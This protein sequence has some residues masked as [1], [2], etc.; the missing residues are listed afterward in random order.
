MNFLIKALRSLAAGVCLSLLILGFPANAG[1]QSQATTGE[2][3]GRVV[4]AQGAAMPGVSVTAK[5]PQTGYVR[6]VVTDGEGL[7]ALPLMPPD[8]YDV[9]YELAG[10]GTV[11]RPIILTVGSTLTANQTLQ[12]SSVAETLTVTASSPLIESSATIRTTTV[13]AQAIRNLPINGRRFQDFATLT[14]TIQVDTQRGQLSFA[15]QRGINA[16]VSIDGADYNQ[17][18]FGGIRGGERS[19]NAFTVP[20]ESIQEFQVIAAG[21]SAEFGRSTGGLMNAITKS[22]TNSVRGTAFYVNRNRDWAEKNAFDQNAAPTQQQFGGS[23]GGPLTKDRLFYFG[24]LEVQKF[25]NTRSVLFN[26]TGISRNS[27]NGEAFDY[28]KS[29]ETP[30]DTTNDAVGLLGRMDYQF[31]GGKRFNIRYSFSDNNAK[32]ANATGNALADTTTSALSNNGTEKDQT[33]TVVGQYTAALKSNLLFEARGQFSREERPRDANE[34]TPLVTTAVGN[35]GTVSF[36]GENI[37]RDWRAQATANVTGVLGRHTVKTGVEYNHVDAFQKFGFNQFGTWNISGTSAVA[38]EILSLGGPNAN[39]FD[40]VSPTATYQKQLGN[41]ELALAT[42]E[43][44]LFAQDTWKVKPGLTLNYGLRWEGAFNPTPQAN[45]DFML[46]ALRGFNFPLGRSV[47]PTQIPDQ[48]SQLGPRVGFA[49][50]PQNNGRTVVRG[51]TGIYYARTPML[52]Y[53]A[54]M[55]NFRIPPGDLSVSLPFTPPAGNTNNTLYKQMALIGIDLNKFPLNGLPVLTTDQI[56]QIASALGLTVNPYLNAAPLVVDRDYKNPRAVQAGVG[57]ERELWPGVT[58]SADMTYVKT[59]NLER[60]RELNLGVPE[61]RPTDPAQRPI[62]ATA[63][64]QPLLGSVQVREPTA[65]SEYTALTLSNRVRK[66]W[67]EVSVNYVLSKS[68][69][70]DDNERDSGGPQYENTYDLSPE[71][72]PARLD[73]R[74]QFNGYVYFFLPYNLDVSTGFKFLSG[75]PIDATFGRDINN[76]RGGADRPYSGP[77]RPFQRNGFRNEPFK[78]VNLRLQWGPRLADSRRVLFTAEFFNIFNWENIQLT[79]TAVTNYCTGTAPDDCGFGAPTNVNF[80]SLTDQNPA[81]A[82]FGQLIRT[83]NP[84][85]PRQIQL[86]V[87]FEF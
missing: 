83:N 64:P 65:S 62:F 76:S 56:T 40:V 47:D 58:V 12:I 42:D 51:F 35:F 53:A 14:P 1:A 84:G 9:S 30:F 45:N 85:A 63:R 18:F 15:G 73:R 59:D 24:S 39:R 61:V 52:L 50:D 23:F 32:N 55:N 26:L 4:D 57:G 87:R 31:A 37:Q 36:L 7:Y 6:T 21:Y 28:Y 82:T 60:N 80:L 71:W 33:N 20:Q 77:G 48:L 38:L 3:N 13:D 17:P 49:W 69:S 46:N 78:E 2:I 41:L 10:F 34:K 16:N 70:D 68:M 74:H 25:K 44:A 75:I 79:G 29:L 22:G 86:G 54:P 8:R 5:S 11:T 27:D 72:G 43:I 66:H 19:N 67:G 81:S